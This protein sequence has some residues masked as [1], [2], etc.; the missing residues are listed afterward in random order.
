MP[1]ISKNSRFGN[2]DGM[3]PTTNWPGAKIVTLFYS[4]TPRDIVRR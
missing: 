4:R 1:H 3:Y 2:D